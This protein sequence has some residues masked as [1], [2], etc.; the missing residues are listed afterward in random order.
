MVATYGLCF[1]HTVCSG[2]FIRS[3]SLVSAPVAM[4]INLQEREHDC[5]G[6][7]SMNGVEAADSIKD[8]LG[9]QDKL[10]AFGIG[11]SVHRR[12]E[13]ELQHVGFADLTVAQLPPHPVYVVKGRGG[14]LGF[15]TTQQLRHYFRKVARD[16]GFP[17]READ[18]ALSC[19]KGRFRL[20]LVLPTQD[21]DL[22]NLANNCPFDFDL[23]DE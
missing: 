18:T 21:N 7:A 20:V 10:R 13:L 8:W 1:R 19:S 22:E 9:E 11:W 16:I 15:N 14:H 23:E 3:G 5:S 17:F 6:L 12:L 2:L 4:N